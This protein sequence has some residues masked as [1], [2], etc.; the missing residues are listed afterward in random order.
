MGSCSPSPAVLVPTRQLE[1]GLKELLPVALHA[2]VLKSVA[3][4]QGQ[5]LGLALGQRQWHRVA[6]GQRQR[7][8][9]R[10]SRGQRRGV[11]IV[12]RQRQRLVAVVARG[13]GGE[14]RVAVAG[15][16]G[17]SRARLQL[18]CGNNTRIHATAHCPPH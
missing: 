3:A 8:G 7:P 4:G 16:G 18:P 17:V 1:R 6:A 9:V 10:I 11:V 14:R 12:V 2:A 13:E 5:G 15:G